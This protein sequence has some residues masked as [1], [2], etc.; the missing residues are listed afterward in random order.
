MDKWKTWSHCWKQMRTMLVK[1][2]D[3][4]WKWVIVSW[5]SPLILSD[6]ER[7]PF[8]NQFFLLCV[9]FR[10]I[11]RITLLL[12]LKGQMLA[13][14]FWT[15]MKNPCFYLKDL[16]LIVK[17]CHFAQ[18][19]PRLKSQFNETHKSS[20]G[21]ISSE[22]PDHLNIWIHLRYIWTLNIWI[23]LNIGNIL[24]LVTRRWDFQ[25]AKYII[26]MR[27]PFSSY[28]DFPINLAWFID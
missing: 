24:S 20:K 3:C 27:L 11:L 23:H 21:L 25:K 15:E 2:A 1:T 5:E 6:G 7:K 4:S 13:N 14:I 9:F 26:E 12:A 19:S 8:F 22:P 28:L 17:I 18:T 16:T 10:F